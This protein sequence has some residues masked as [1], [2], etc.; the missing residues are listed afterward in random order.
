M[1]NEILNTTYFHISGIWGRERDW[2]LSNFLINLHT[3]LAIQSNT[4]YHINIQNH[5]IIKEKSSEITESDHSLT[6][7]LSWV[8]GRN[9]LQSLPHTAPAGQLT[10]A[11]N[12]NYSAAEAMSADISLAFRMKADSCSFGPALAH[13]CTCVL[14][15]VCLPSLSPASALFLCPAPEALKWH[16]PRALSSARNITN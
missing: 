9:R 5:R 8:V 15:W 12:W 16:W 13:G 6:T 10:P 14:C 4:F 1:V 11:W 7:V 2:N 3:S